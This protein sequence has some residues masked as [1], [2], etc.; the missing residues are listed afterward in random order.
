MIFGDGWSLIFPDI[1][2]RVEEKSRKKLQPGKLTQPGI[3]PERARWEATMLPLDHSAGQDL[4]I[5]VALYGDFPVSLIIFAALFQTYA[6]TLVRR[7]SVIVRNVQIL[8]TEHFFFLF[9]S[10]P[11][12]NSFLGLPTIE[13]DGVGALLIFFHNLKLPV[14]T[15]FENSH[16]ATYYRVIHILRA[17]TDGCRSRPCLACPPLHGASNC[18]CSQTLALFFSSVSE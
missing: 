6:V 10:L 11:S 12:W 14:Y 7:E 18:R 4:L 1:C 5:L 3:E 16:F 15:V 17:A 13:V 8:G 9:L 2:L